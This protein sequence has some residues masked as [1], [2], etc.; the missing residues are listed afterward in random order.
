MLLKA[1]PTNVL[2]TAI[3]FAAPDT[4][5]VV[6]ET[7]RISVWCPVSDVEPLTC[8]LTTTLA[9]A[10]PFTSATTFAAPLGLLS[11]SRRNPGVPC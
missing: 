10:A 3:P 4:E 2:E 6:G 7:N 1:C 9:F 5:V 11:T 8:A